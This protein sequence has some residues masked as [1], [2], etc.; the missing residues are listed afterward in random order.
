MSSFEF[1][2]VDGDPIVRFGIR[3][4]LTGG[5]Q[6]PTVGE[7]APGFR[8]RDFDV[9]ATRL[10]VQI[11][12]GKFGAGPERIGEIRQYAPRVPLLVLAASVDADDVVRGLRAGATSFLRHTADIGELRSA[13]ETT[14]RGQRYLGND[15]AALL[16]EHLVSGQPRKHA[17]LS[18]RELQVMLRLAQGRRVI[19]VAREL[20]LSVKTVSSHR[21]R[22]L[23][24]M[25]MKSNTDLTR[26]ALTHKLIDGDL[27][28]AEADPRAPS[29]DSGPQPAQPRG[30]LRERA[31]HEDWLGKR[32][33]AAPRLP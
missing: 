20:C 15:I 31:P 27:G 13:I 11:A 19:D 26:Y 33:E 28:D 17:S 21:S 25:A 24:K 18:N 32:I 7:V 6:G 9:A 16:S 3:A 2:V 1:I 23:K 12:N 5:M 29:I 4:L 14:C 30:A 22:L 8:F 10:I